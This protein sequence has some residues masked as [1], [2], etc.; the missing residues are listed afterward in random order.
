MAQSSPGTRGVGP[1]LWS[2]LLM[3]CVILVVLHLANAVRSEASGGEDLLESTFT[4]VE[5]TR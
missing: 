4:T 1:T 2:L 5:A 3:A